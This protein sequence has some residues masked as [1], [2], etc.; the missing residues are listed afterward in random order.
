MFSVIVSESEELRSTKIPD[1]ISKCVYVKCATHLATKNLKH[2]K[3]SG[4]DDLSISVNL[5]L[6]GLFMFRWAWPLLF[7]IVLIF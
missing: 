4:Y 5:P 2:K 3:G 7:K 6:D 1:M